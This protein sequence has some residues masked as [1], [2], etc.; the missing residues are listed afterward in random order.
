MPALTTPGYDGFISYSHAA[1]GHLAP[2]L[3]GGLQSLSK[4][5]YRRRALRVFRDKTSLSAS[6]QLWP[7]IE[8]ALSR[9]RYFVLLASP[10][11]ARSHW[12]EQEVRWWRAHRSH[13][14]L[15]IAL[16]DG[17]LGWDGALGDF[18]SAAAIPPALRGWFPA[19]PLWVD[20]RWARGQRDLSMRNPRFRDGVG[21]LAAPL[22]GLPK[23][24]LI[25]EDISQHRRTVRLARAAVATLVLLLVAAVVGGLVALEQRNRAEDER[26]LAFARELATNSTAQRSTDPEL[27]LLLGAEAV[28]TRAIPETE[29][30]LRAALAGNHLRAVIPAGEQ[31]LNDAE[32]SPDGKTALTAGDDG[33]VR[34]FEVPS[35]VLTETF[36]AGPPGLTHAAF[37]RKG[38]LVLTTNERSASKLWDAVTGRLVQ[39][40]PDRAERV[41]G[42]AISPDGE[43]IAT[44]G[45]EGLH[46]WTRGGRSRGVIWSPQDSIESVAFSPDG[47]LLA[48]ATWW[49]DLRVWRL[50]EGI[51]TPKMRVRPFSI[52]SISFDPLGRA[53]LT[54]SE[55]GVVR[56]WD[57]A[58]GKPTTLRKEASE[59][60]YPR[61][62]L[63]A[64]VSSDRSL[65]AVGYGD[66]T[67]AVEDSTE[68]GRDFT[69]QTG[70]V[71]V[72]DL[73]FS[74]DGASIVTAQADG[75]ARL[76]GVTATDRL[77]ATLGST[78]GA[79]SVA[80]SADGRFV[81][82][83]FTA[84]LEFHGVDTSL[85]PRGV[86]VWR[87]S[88]RRAWRAS[89]KEGDRRADFSPDA[90]LVA[91]A[92]KAGTRVWRIFARRPTLRFSGPSTDVAF[93]PDGS[94]LAIV[95]KSGEVRVRRLSDGRVVEVLR[96]GSARGVRR[97]DF[98]A[99]G[100]SLLALGTDGVIR[101]WNRDE[102]TAAQRFGD[103]DS[104]FAGA[105]LSPS[106]D[107]IAVT[108]DTRLGEIDLESGETTWTAPVNSSG[109]RSVAYSADGRVILVVGDDDKATVF[110]AESLLPITD[111]TS[112]SLAAAAFGDNS[113]LVALADSG[114]LRVY[115]CDLC[116]SPTRLL[117]IARGRVSRGLSPA[118]R[119][120][121]LH[122]SG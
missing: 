56:R 65:L 114:G 59:T 57:V 63:A 30:A 14:T 39:V 23:D 3:Q 42:G 64:K 86:W 26:N 41:S 44:A 27:A 79:N 16:T 82:A 76:F 88:D 45:L 90:D 117:T 108:S 70:G 31:Q 95:E 102:G 55:D 11:A 8:G 109:L 1:D 92:G 18:D 112:E 83:V 77:V 46:L 107:A 110:D 119:R 120:R 13:D 60:L 103:R 24:E 37:A 32:F 81:A 43:L 118:E 78:G 100:S 67:L 53:V 71:E 115:R 2:A 20:L 10:E 72:T 62:P 12:I 73:D 80:F 106:G 54:A 34:I 5:W 121:Y 105:A 69:I 94:L 47:K 58:S 93:S 40:L 4:P 61:E 29:N 49:R 75:T 33:K 85:L 6:P 28:R 84:S 91:I 96:G 48:S 7:S 98:S 74:P 101:L 68:H 50:D 111:F 21:D 15:L 9:S 97:V 89:A 116:A 122:E 38:N 17:E 25:G 99:D 36:R 22:H 51:A 35:G 104:H 66:G 113:A 87:L 52:Q 19:E